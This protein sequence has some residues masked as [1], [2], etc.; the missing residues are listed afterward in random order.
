MPSLRRAVAAVAVAC[1]APLA[2]GPAGAEPFLEGFSGVNV[3]RDA[4]VRIRQPAATSDFTV[5][6]LSF[7]PRLSD[8]APYY[9]LRAGYFFGEEPAWLGVALEL[10]HFKVRG[11]VQDAR[12]VSGTLDGSPV[13]A[14]LPVDTVVQRFSIANG[15]NYLMVDAIVRRG[16]LVDEDYPH[17]RVQ[18]YAGAGAGPVITYTYSTVR[19]E[20]RSTGYELGGPGVQAFAGVRVLLF[21]HVGLFVEGKYTHAWLGVGVPRDGQADVT[22]SSVHLVGGLSLV[23]P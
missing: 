9:G 11:E 5:H 6:D 12:R 4:D 22:E 3:T 23:F 19:G 21:R 17:G 1:S 16:L 13:D 18:L 10:F 20:R 15:I 2:A 7:T 14:R 8:G